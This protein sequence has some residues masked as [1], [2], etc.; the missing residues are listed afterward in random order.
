VLISAVDHSSI[1]LNFPSLK[2]E[3]LGKVKPFFS[4]KDFGNDPIQKL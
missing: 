2:T 1:L 3:V 4:K